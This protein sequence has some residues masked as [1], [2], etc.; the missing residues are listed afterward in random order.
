MLHSMDLPA[1]KRPKCKYCN[2]TNTLA[3]YLEALITPNKVY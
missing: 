3:Y 2:G 1:N